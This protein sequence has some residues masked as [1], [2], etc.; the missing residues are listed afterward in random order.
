[1]GAFVSVEKWRSILENVADIL[2][3]HICIADAAGMPIVIPEQPKYGWKFSPN[4]LKVE[5]NFTHMGDGRFEFIDQYQLHY[6]AVA[7]VSI[8]NNINGYVILGPVILNKRL[9]KSEYEALAKQNGDDI[10][11]FNSRLEE[12]R[13]IS[14]LNLE[15]IIYTISDF[16]KLGQNNLPPLE[17]QKFE[18]GRTQIILES[19]LDLSLAIANAESGS[20]MLFDEQTN[21]LS[22]HAAKGLDKTYLK[23]RIKLHE[24]ISGIAF[25]NKKT[26]ILKSASQPEPI[27]G[28]LNR[29]DI[30][31]SMVMPFETTDKKTRGVLNVNIMRHDL[32]LKGRLESVNK[33]LLEITSN[34]LQVI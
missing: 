27:Q 21:E 5:S 10:D 18:T 31:Q 16:I 26:M 4:F 33:A 13:I 17:S 8:E 2:R 14:H 24:G 20:I 6:Y 32:D 12:I 22:I 23:R 11:G 28:L 34:V 7:C 1:M 30:Y 25:K 15:Y 3:I 29:K 9:G 19:M